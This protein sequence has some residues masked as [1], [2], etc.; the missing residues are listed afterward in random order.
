MGDHVHPLHAE[1]DE[2]AFDAPWN[3]RQGWATYNRNHWLDGDF[4]AFRQF[5]FEQMCSEPHSSKVFDDLMEW[6]AP[7]D[8]QVLADATAGR[9]GLDGAV[10]APLDD[11]SRQVRCPVSVI[12]GT[13]DR[14]RPIAIG[15][16]LA[17]LTGGS[18]L[19]VQGG[20][21]AW[22]GGSPAGSYT[23]PLGPDASREMLRFFLEHPHPAPGT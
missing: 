10:C 2:H 9:I 16:R 17:E 4:A 20:G 15:E 6:S 23:D 8:T 3:G 18:L 7:T 13:D 5:F 12:H 14:I 11:A 22:S 19:A 21:H 1:R